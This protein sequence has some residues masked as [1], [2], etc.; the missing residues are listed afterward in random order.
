[1]SPG[2]SLRSSPHLTARKRDVGRRQG[3]GKETRRKMGRREGTED[4]MEGRMGATQPFL[5]SPERPVGD[6]QDK[7]VKMKTSVF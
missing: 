7:R 2:K 3:A 6:P 1:M 4:R 5:A